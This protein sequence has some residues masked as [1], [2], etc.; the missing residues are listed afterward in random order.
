MFHEIYLLQ[1][2]GILSHPYVLIM[3]AL[4]Q[5]SIHLLGSTAR[6]S[7]SRVVFSF[8]INVAFVAACF[9]AAKESTTIAK[10]VLLLL[11]FITSHNFMFDMCLK[12][13]FKG[14]N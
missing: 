11:P 8:T 5:A 9:Y 4:E 2:L 1:V 12:K 13:P 7:D 10:L 14:E 6:A 3:Y